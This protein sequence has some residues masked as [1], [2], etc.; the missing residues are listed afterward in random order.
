MV[1][2]DL[3]HGVVAQE[4]VDHV[5]NVCICFRI[6]FCCRRVS[7]LSGVCRNLLQDNARSLLC[8]A[9]CCLRIGLFAR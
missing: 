2:T 5:A 6:R 4:V 9:A 1:K 3:Q 8:C 7:W